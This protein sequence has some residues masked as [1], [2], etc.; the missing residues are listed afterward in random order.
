MFIK[1]TPW[2][3]NVRASCWGGNT[4]QVSN[5]TWDYRTQQE[6]GGAAPLIKRERSHDRLIV[7]RTPGPQPE[8]RRRYLIERSGFV[9]REM[10]C[11]ESH[12]GEII[13]FGKI[14]VRWQRE[15]VT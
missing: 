8:C 13:C 11:C 10:I 7:P 3:P 9:K 6:S 12:S 4:K 5:L 14:W 2:K 15:Y 1:S